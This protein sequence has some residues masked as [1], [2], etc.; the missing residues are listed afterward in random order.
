MLAHLL[1]QQIHIQ[2]DWTRQ[3]HAQ[4]N[5]HTREHIY[6]IVQLQIDAAE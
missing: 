4:M 5:L 2:N 1:L 6:Q 3:F